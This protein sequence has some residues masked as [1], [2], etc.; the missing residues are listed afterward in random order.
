[1]QRLDTTCCLAVRGPGLQ[2]AQVGFIFFSLGFLD[3]PFPT[4]ELVAECTS[5]S[6]PFA[7]PTAKNR[8]NWTQLSGTRKISTRTRQA[9]VWL[10]PRAEELL[11]EF[12]DS[13]RQ[14]GKSR[15]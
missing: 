3:K 14:L 11:A 13:D 1:M 15:K 5:N 7:E 9:C 6:E 10:A 2:D 8:S 4:F 12:I